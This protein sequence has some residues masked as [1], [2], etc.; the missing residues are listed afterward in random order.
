VVVDSLRLECSDDALAPL[1]TRLHI[2]AGETSGIWRLGLWLLAPE[3]PCCDA[4]E[5]DEH[6]ADVVVVASLELFFALKKLE[7]TVW[8]ESYN[9]QSTI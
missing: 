2:V 1:L 4:D 7:K 3:V 8:D 9:K 5:C 6:D